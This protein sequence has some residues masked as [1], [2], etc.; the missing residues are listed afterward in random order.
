MRERSRMSAGAADEPPCDSEE[1]KR[2]L[3]PEVWP[4]LAPNLVDG[5]RGAKKG[6]VARQSLIMGKASALLC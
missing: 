3:L 6:R 2:D 4:Q 5:F 1:V